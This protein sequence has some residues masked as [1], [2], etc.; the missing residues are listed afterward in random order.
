MSLSPSAADLAERIIEIRSEVFGKGRSGLLAVASQLA[1]PE[2][3]WAN[4]EAGVTIPATIL[5]RFIV[6]TDVSSNWLLTGLGERFA[7]SKSFD[8]MMEDRFEEDD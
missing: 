6:L 2:Q 7:S 8:P 1:L 4:Y 3:T 5:I